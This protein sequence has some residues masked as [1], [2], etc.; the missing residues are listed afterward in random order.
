MH[1]IQTAVSQKPLK[2]SLKGRRFQIIEE[3]R[4]SAIRELR[5]ITESAFQKA[6]KQWKKRWKRCI[7]SR[8]DCFER[9][10]AYNSVK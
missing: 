5:A 6:F 1:N 7:T 3:I 9:A 2:T 4:K 10:S 8:G